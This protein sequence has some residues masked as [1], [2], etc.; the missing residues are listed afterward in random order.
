MEAISLGKKEANEEDPTKKVEIGSELKLTQ[1][2]IDE[3]VD[4]VATMRVEVNKQEKELF[5]LKDTFNKSHLAI[6]SL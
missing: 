4:L 5:E 3:L 6:I 2:E 1:N